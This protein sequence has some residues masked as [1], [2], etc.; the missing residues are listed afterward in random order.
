MKKFN[1]D[2]ENLDFDK[3]WNLH[4]RIHEWWYMTGYFYDEDNNLYSYQYT[5]ISPTYLFFRPKVLMLALTD[6]KNDKHYYNQRMKLFTSFKINDNSLEFLNSKIEK[7]DNNLYLKAEADDFSLDLK[8]SLNKK[9]IWHSDNGII[10]MGTDRKE[11]TTFY[12]SYTNMNTEG[13]I[14]LNGKK[15]KVKGKSWFD[16]QGG[17]FKVFDVNT[18]WEWFSLRFYDDEELMLFSYP[19][20]PKF[21]DGTYI[22][23]DNTKERVSNY[24]LE[25]HNF[26]EARGYKFSNNWT[27][28]VPGIKEEK[29]EI[30]A[31]SDGQINLAYYEQLCKIYNEEDKEVGLCFVELLPGVYND[32]IRVKDLF[33]KVGKDE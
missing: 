26:V 4:K 27:L 22:K 29:Y 10:K 18:H 20:N 13:T 5:V 7:V 16:K 2:L 14:T 1:Y 12:Y 9:A 21:N 17:T 30:K 11:D 32:K 8:N 25:A 33:K 19:R 6:F 23:K 24:S 31:I 28:I 15:I 3:E